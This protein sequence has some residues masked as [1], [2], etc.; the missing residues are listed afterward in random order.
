MAT[1]VAEALAGTIATQVAR[2]LSQ[3]ERISVEAIQDLVEQ[4]LMAH[5]H[6]DAAKHY[7]LYREQHRKLRAERPIDEGTKE[8]FAETAKHFTG[9]HRQ[10]QLT[11]AF[12]KFSRFNHNI[13]RRETWL[14]TA[15]RV[16]GF[17]RSE[18][19]KQDRQLPPELWQELHHGLVAMEVTPSLRAV[20]MAGPPLERCN[21]GVFNCWFQGMD[22]PRAM[23]EELYL[24][25][26]GGGVGFSVESRYVDAW[27]RV[28]KQTTKHPATPVGI[29][30]DTEAW[31]DAVQ[32]GLQTWLDG[33][34]VEFDYSAIR[35]KGAVLRT[36]GGRSSGPEPL[37]NLLTFMRQ[38]VLGA[39]G[40]RLTSLEIHD[41]TCMTHRIVL[42]GGVRRASGISLSDL[43]DTDLRD[44]KKGAFWNQHEYRNQANNSAVY[45]EKPSAVEFMEEWLSLA[46][47]GSGERGIFNR[48]SLHKQL[49]ERRKRRGL[50]FGCNPCGE[51]VLRSRQ[52]CNLSIAV[53]RGADNVEDLVRKT[54]LAAL[55][56][57]CQSLLT[58]FRYLNS[59]WAKNVAEE[60]L[61]GVDIMGGMD[62]PLL[63]PGAPGREQL[64]QRLRHE[65]IEVDREWAER[66]Q[67]PYSAATTCVKPGGDSSVLL[68][69][70]P[71]L[72]PYHGEHYIRRIRLE[73]ENPVAK[74]LTD[75]GVP[76]FDDYDRSGMR[77]FEFPCQ[78]PAGGI[79]LAQHQSMDQ[80]ENW[81]EWKRHYTEHN[82]SV[83]VMVRPEDWLAVG[84]WV[85][86]HW[87]E[88]GGLSFFPYDGGVYPLAPYETISA[89][90]YA[91]RQAAFPE[92]EWWKIARYE[93][94][95][96][97][98][99]SQT[100]ACAGGACQI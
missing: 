49:P 66:W 37:R 26:Q 86:A 4:Q 75:A 99:L 52:A 54:R 35:P 92:I 38:T 72:K 89:E 7:I 95:D 65:V 12:D 40:R 58:R 80:L 50:V 16:V 79:T 48:G 45:D 42:L 97:T 13:G 47:S 56:G 100:V 53:G 76:V 27:P 90:E 21:S 28:R 22:G 93:Q 20:Q 3:R 5:G 30:D 9:P 25:M 84:N 85:Y 1:E 24:L 44:C 39:Q 19:A 64:F 71:S 62:C 61:L 82:P 55:W 32:L 10:L 17:F 67:L 2:I 43:D 88:V 41:M 73:R 29:E 63:L 33:R 83:S 14:E 59:E 68:D 8:I 36:K 11:Q 31:C 46:K 34:D 57:I 23:A 15:D 70:S 77:V 51:V 60:R 96:N 87:D 94:E 74:V 69:T 91:Q 78:A 98:T 6:Y 18:L 81:L